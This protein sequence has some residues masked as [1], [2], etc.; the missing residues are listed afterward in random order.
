LSLQLLGAYL[1]RNL[2]RPR[3]LLGQT[4]TTIWTGPHAKCPVSPHR[5]TKATILNLDM[6]SGLH[7]DAFTRGCFGEMTR[8]DSVVALAASPHRKRNSSNRKFNLNFTVEGSK[9]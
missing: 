3:L 4:H 6:P 2:T 5:V 9:H 1:M 8:S 7:V